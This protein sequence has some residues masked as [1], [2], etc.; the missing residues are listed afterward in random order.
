MALVFVEDGAVGNG[1]LWELYRIRYKV[2]TGRSL[3]Q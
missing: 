3:L 1:S 2:A